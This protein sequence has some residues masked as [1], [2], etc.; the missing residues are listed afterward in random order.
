MYFNMQEYIKFVP[1]KDTPVRA[2]T[3]FSFVSHL[4]DFPYKPTTRPKFP[5]FKRSHRPV[6]C[7]EAMEEKREEEE[8]KEEEE[9]REEK[10]E[11]EEEKGLSLFDAPE[12]KPSIT[13]D[14]S[15]IKRTHRPVFD[16]NNH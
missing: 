8:K 15:R 11:E 6:Y 5:Q 1:S 13:I 4:P 16:Y 12:Y 9:K 14:R 10:R 7:I 3:G 2:G